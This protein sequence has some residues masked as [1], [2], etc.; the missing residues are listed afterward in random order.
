MLGDDQ[1]GHQITFASFLSLST[2]SATEPTL[3]P[4][5]ALRR[6]LDLERDQARREI[7][8]ESGGRQLLDRLLLRLHDVGQ[9][10]VARLVEPQIG[11]DDRRQLERDRLQPA[12]DLARD[13]RLAALDRELRGEG[14]LR[15]AEQGRQHLAGLVAVVVDRLLAEDDELGC[16]FVDDRL[17][18]LGDRE[19]L[20]LGIGL[21][22]DAAI[23]AH[24]ERG[25]DRLLALLR[26]H[27]DGDDLAGD[28]GFLE[29]NR[30]LDADLV[31]RV[32]R[33]LDVR[34]SRRRCCPP[35][36]G[37][38]RCSRSPA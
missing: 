10:G 15:P 7:D 23:G 1:D 14:A 9:R 35:S 3:L 31:E 27:R 5:L 38:S 2:S 29:P 33:H 26:A 37:P 36:P 8:A 21:D 24:G 6:L 22:L 34:R 28:A 4:A 18:Q 13:L 32:H 11:G 19:R 17:Q 30:L 25:A 12:I 16:S 20:Q